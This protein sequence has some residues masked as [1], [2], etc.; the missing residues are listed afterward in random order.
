MR[1]VFGG[2]DLCDWTSIS[3]EMLKL[4]KPKKV[5]HRRAVKW[6]FHVS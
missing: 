6:S 1:N 3:F 4:L 2:L 5:G